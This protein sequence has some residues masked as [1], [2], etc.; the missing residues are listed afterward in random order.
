MWLGSRSEP[1]L[2]ADRDTVWSWNPTTGS[3]LNDFLSSLAEFT[4]AYGGDKSMLMIGYWEYGDEII[5]TA[6]TSG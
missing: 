3:P 1:N 5:V 6:P 4:D 2:T